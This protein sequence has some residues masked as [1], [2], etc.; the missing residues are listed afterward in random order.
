MFIDFLNIKNKKLDKYKLIIFYGKSWTW[1]STNLNF[2]FNNFETKILIH[3]KTEKIKYRYLKEENIF[4]DEISSLYWL[5]TVS[6]FLLSWKKVFIASHIHP[7]FFLVIF[8]LFY[9][10][11]PFYTNKDNNKIEIY[12]KEKWYNYSETD[13][14]VFL[15]RFWSN[16][17]DLQIVLDFYTNEK[18]FSKI[19]YKF[20]KECNLKKV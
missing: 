20:S 8:W 12:I 13:I 2:F 5:C 4:I 17:L 10:I 6:R 7:F 18:D 14:K 15:D 19:L 16:L 9:K 11:K 3:H 1:K